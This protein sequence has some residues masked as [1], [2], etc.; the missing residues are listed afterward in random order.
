MDSREPTLD[1]ELERL[2]RTHTPPAPA[3]SRAFRK[4]LRAHFIA[5]TQ[6]LGDVVPAAWSEP[7]PR[8][9]LRVRPALVGL[10]AAALLLLTVLRPGAN[11]TRVVSASELIERNAEAWIDVRDV[12]GWYRDAEGRRYEEWVRFEGSQ[13]PLYR[14]L[15]DGPSLLPGV[16]EQWNISNGTYEW[17]V[18]GADGRVV[19]Q[20]FLAGEGTQLLATPS[21]L[22]CA[23]LELPSELSDAS[24]IET[25]LEGVSVFR[26]SGT[27]HGQERVYWIDGA[28]FL[29][30]RIDSEDGAVLWQR[31]DIAVNT[32]LPRR[33]FA[34]GRT[35]RLNL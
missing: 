27:V 14:R 22:Q 24:V 11:D 9:A 18:D 16:A 26:M 23:F 21:D 17:L 7:S 10:A 4:G 2:L 5:E 15:L 33:E 34:P 29:V 35:E 3:P 20:V 8:W 28:D 19:E 6:R 1:P 12:K 31:G 13:P 25:D 32:G 30:R